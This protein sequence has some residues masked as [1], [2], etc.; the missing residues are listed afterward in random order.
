MHNNTELAVS[1]YHDA[2]NTETDIRQFNII[3]LILSNTPVWIANASNEI[4][5]I[6]WVFLRIYVQMPNNKH[7][8]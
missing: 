8:I 2:K 3:L 5:Q 1:M 6:M 7:Y 4:I